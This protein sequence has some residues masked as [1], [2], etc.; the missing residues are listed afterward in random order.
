MRRPTDTCPADRDP[1]P[2]ADTEVAD[3]PVERDNL[4]EMVTFDDVPDVSRT[5]DCSLRKLR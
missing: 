4:G 2:A 1:P 5:L 3:E